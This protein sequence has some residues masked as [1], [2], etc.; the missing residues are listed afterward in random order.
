MCPPSANS[1]SKIR[2]FICELP[3]YTPFGSG[4][5][6]NLVPFYEVFKTVRLVALD[7]QSFFKVW[8]TRSLAA[9]DVGCVMRDMQGSISDFLDDFF[10]YESMGDN[11]FNWK[12]SIVF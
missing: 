5:N 7:T 1:I 10:L 3:F 2:Q 8:I 6:L 12:S 9:G 4:Q 11:F